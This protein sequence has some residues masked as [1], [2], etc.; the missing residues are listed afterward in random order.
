MYAHHDGVKL[1]YQTTGGSG[2]ELFLHPPSQPVVYS[3]AWKYQ[4]AYLPRS[5]RV[6]G[7]APRGTAR[8]ARPP[9][10]YDLDTRY[11]DLLA[12]LDAAVRPPF[13]FVALAC[14]AMLAFRYAVEHPARL[15]HPT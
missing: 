2:P 15:S 1:F 12:V 10:G 9:T 3:R 7:P 5:S 14:S 13:A 11:R 8:P 4:L 6:P